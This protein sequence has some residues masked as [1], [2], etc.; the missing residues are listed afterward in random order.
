MRCFL[1][2]GQGHTLADQQQAGRLPGLQVEAGGQPQ[3]L[4]PAAPD[5]HPPLH[6][7][8]ITPSQ[9][10]AVSGR[11][12]DLEHKCLNLSPRSMP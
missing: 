11:G 6:P 3:L 9:G 7:P 2:C 8:R 10:G 5:H 4:V 12:S 1:Y